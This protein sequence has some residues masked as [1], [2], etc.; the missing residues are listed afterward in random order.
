MINIKNLDLKIDNNHILKNINLSFPSRGIIGICGPSGCGK[1]SLLNCIGGIKNH[2]GE[3]YF[4]NK[5]ISRMTFDEM[6]NFRLINIGIIYQDFNLFENETV[7]NNILL[8]LISGSNITQERRKQAVEDALNI[9]E[10]KGFN[11]KIVHTLSGGQ[12][13][14]VALAR[15]IINQPSCLL[16]D[17]PSAQLDRKNSIKIFELFKKISQH[18]LVVV[19]SH[20]LKL[21]SSYCQQIIYLEDGE[22]RRIEDISPFTLKEEHI[23]PKREMLL[24]NKLPFSFIHKHTKHA[25][26]EKKFRSLLLH[27]VISIALTSIGFSF[28][29]S[30]IVS[31][32]VSNQYASL[33]SDYELFAIP[34]NN[35]T[36]NQINALSREEAFYL[37]EIYP[38]YIYDVGCGY[39]NDFDTF[40]KDM[41]QFSFS[42]NNRVNKIEDIYI[43]HVNDFLWLDLYQ[44]LTIYPSKPSTLLNEQIVLGLTI[45]NIRDIC[46]GLRITRTVETLSNYL[47]TNTLYVKLHVANTDWAYEDEHIFQVVGFTLEN[48][49]KIY[50]YNHMWNEY[51]LENLMLLPT[52]DN[53]NGLLFYPWTLRKIYYLET[54]NNKDEILILSCTD[55]NFDT[56]KVDVGSKNVFPTINN[57][58]SLSSRLILYFNNFDN[59]LPRI[60]TNLIE[61]DANLKSCI[62]ATSSSYGFYPSAL[63]VGFNRQLYCSF[64]Q[65]LIDEVVDLSSSFND[66]QKTQIDLPKGVVEGYLTKTATEGVRFSSLE[67]KNILH[68]RSPASLDEIVVSSSLLT[69]LGYED[70]QI[71]NEE[72]LL[73][74][75]FDETQIENDKTLKEFNYSSLKIVGIVKSDNLYLYHSP[76]WIISYFQSRHFVSIFELLINGFAFELKDS[77]KSSESFKLLEKALPTC[78]IYS[79]MEDI[80]TNIQSITSYI[81]IGILCFSLISLITSLLLAILCLSLYFADKK[82]DYGLLLCIGLVK[83]E[84]MK[85]PLYYIF[86]ICLISFLISS[87]QIFGICLIFTIQD[88]SIS[89][90]SSFLSSI[91]VMASLAFILGLSSYLFYYYKY[92]NISIFDAL[93]K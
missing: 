88:P 12:R 44:S 55:E 50:H 81:K 92:K 69:K 45:Q 3:I 32:S 28:L 84:M 43:S 20:D 58:E 18:T 57:L 93:N 33:I 49:N 82:K 47:K 76:H 78:D 16:A 71:P 30:S 19:V 25:K 42:F 75:C 4:D 68:G 77:T 85:L 35:I 40:F 52:S 13:Q 90:I 65:T 14:R 83:K 53:L 56:I 31:I 91:F 10:L 86:N 51:V 64:S 61:N 38:D 54:L 79:P 24:K 89:L 29:I 59:F 2:E 72:L 87:L 17:E 62:F 63:M 9:C 6:C 60:A 27:F 46:Y 22:V 21:L 8:P 74:Y 73:A 70:N 11:K 7:E 66:D 1:S 48:E 36:N 5:C 41:N 67:E 39:I 23:V 80:R 15:S 34:K 37:K 26:K